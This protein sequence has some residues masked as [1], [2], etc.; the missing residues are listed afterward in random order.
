[1]GE[2]NSDRDEIEVDVQDEAYN[3]PIEW[4]DLRWNSSN[5]MAL[6]GISV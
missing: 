3:E 6:K 4:I 2:L 5:G 1:M